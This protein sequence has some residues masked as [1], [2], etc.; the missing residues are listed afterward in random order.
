MAMCV[1]G[2]LLEIL[3][4]ELLVIIHQ[5]QEDLHV[6]I[7]DLFT[8]EEVRWLLT[9]H[10]K[11][12]L[13]NYERSDSGNTR[14]CEMQY[15]EA[16]DL[17]DPYPFDS[18]IIL[19]GVRIGANF[20]CVNKGAKFDAR[21]EI[22]SLCGFFGPRT[23]ILSEDSRVC[24]PDVWSVLVILE[25]RFS[26][27]GVSNPTAYALT[28][29]LEYFDEVMQYHLDDPIGR[30]AYLLGSRVTCGLS[31]LMTDRLAGRYPN[32]G[33]VTEETGRDRDR[34]EKE[35]RAA[36]HAYTNTNI[37]RYLARVLSG[38]AFSRSSP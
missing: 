3:P 37:A 38:D 27:S 8:E 18:V 36:L 20:R 13:A 4:S 31:T 7:R 23:R 15:L 11:L 17:P 29:T 28:I 12:V 25:R 34:Y 24:L 35:I 30:E 22:G 19:Y 6:R 33:G 21:R 2:T 14:R 1:G 32:S 5:H 10:H 9:I 16:P 26:L